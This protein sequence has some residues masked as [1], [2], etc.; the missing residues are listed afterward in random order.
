MSLV[1]A[2]AVGLDQSAS[3]PFEVAEEGVVGEATRLVV[4]HVEDGETAGDNELRS[5]E[6]VDDAGLAGRAGEAADLVQEA[7]HFVPAEG[8]A[9]GVEVVLDED[10]LLALFAKQGK[11]VPGV[12]SRL[13]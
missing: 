4:G 11:V 2:R 8:G 13:V 10:G 5:L 3:V 1:E 6:V 12:P 7:S 9:G